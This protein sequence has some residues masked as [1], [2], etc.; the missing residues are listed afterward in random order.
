MKLN[1]KQLFK[2]KVWYNGM[3]F[4]KDYECNAFQWGEGH[5]G[6]LMFDDIKDP[7][8]KRY[9]ISVHHVDCIEIELIEGERT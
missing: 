3:G 6:I 5:S 1:E 9:F 2:I 7:S 4:F 8:K